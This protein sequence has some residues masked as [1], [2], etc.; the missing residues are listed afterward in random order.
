MKKIFFNKKTDS[1]GFTL[2]ELLSIIAVLALV[3][4]MTIFFVR[5]FFDDTAIKIDEITKNMIIDA[6][7]E[8]TIEY[9]GSTN[10]REDERDD[11]I[12]F[13]ISLDSLL[14]K[15]FFENDGSNFE[16]YRD[17][18]AVSGIS[19]NGKL[20]YEL[21]L[22]S[23]VDED[24]ICEYKE[25]TSSLVEKNLET[26]E[27]IEVEQ[28]TKEL[29][30]VNDDI[31]LGTFKYDI[32][33]VGDKYKINTSSSLKIK[34]IINVSSN[35]FVNILLDESSSIRTDYRSA[36]NAIKDLSR[37][38]NE[39]GISHSLIGFGDYPVLRRNFSV[40]P[41]VDNDFRKTSAYTDYAWA[42]N[43][44][45]AVDLATS[46]IYNAKY[47]DDN[48]VKMNEDSQIYT[49]IFTD[50]KPYEWLWIQKEVDGVV[51]DKKDISEIAKDTTNYNFND[52]AKE[53]YSR[54]QKLVEGCSGDEGN[55]G[56]SDLVSGDR[57]YTCGKRSD[58]TDYYVV[59]QNTDSEKDRAWDYLLHSSGFLKSVGSKVI[60]AAY[61]DDFSNNKNLKD[62]ISV[63]NDF[64]SNSSMVNGY[65]YYYSRE[66]NEIA[67]LFNQFEEKFKEKFLVNKIKFKLDPILD[68]N[69][70]PFVKIYDEAGSEVTVIDEFD[71]TGEEFKGKEEIDILN[72]FTFVVNEESDLFDEESMNCIDDGKK[73]TY[74]GTKK[75]FEIK[76]SLHY[77]KDDSWTDVTV[78]QPEF[79]LK[80]TKISTVN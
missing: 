42:T 23:S 27:F 24:N 1:N 18:F 3:I 79:D 67:K 55:G 36:V 25:G 45:A 22:L 63:D 71:L 40:E 53:Y 9:R 41:L 15:G 49:I 47:N 10:W 20:E 73:C 51:S 38:L 13:C 11:G 61:I 78:V 17:K 50:G 35:T 37:T 26:G 31:D 56:Y 62:V 64:C 58:N 14:S 19:K 8:Y 28:V 16:Q 6:A 65:C 46:L 77:A 54:Y 33:C 80:L 2:I 72:K 75:L 43:S 59:F 5:D 60:I 76:L 32:T 44:M 39:L 69:G 74:E 21:V 48:G 29:E 70:I 12:Y 4:T 30:I 66:S 68:S 52:D 57:Q 7:N 34:E